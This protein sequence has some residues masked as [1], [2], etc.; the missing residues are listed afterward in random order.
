[1]MS[2]TCRRCRNR[3]EVDAAF[4]G[5][6]L[7][8]PSCNSAVKIQAEEPA[9]A[10]AAPAS[11]PEASP[12]ASPGSAPPAPPAPATPAPAPAPA[13]EAPKSKLRLAGDRIASGEGRACPKCSFIMGTDDV[14][15]A[16]C[17]HNTRTGVS[18]ADVARRR[19]A[20]R[21]FLKLA[22]AVLVLVALGWIVWKAGWLSFDVRDL[23]AEDP[24]PAATGV[25]PETVPGPTGSGLPP[26]PPEIVAEVTRQVTEAFRV[27]HPVVAEGMGAAFERMDGRVLRGVF[28]T[29]TEPGTFILETM[30]G[31]PSTHAFE[32]LKPSFR[33]RCDPAYRADQIALEVKRRLG[34]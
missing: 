14:V 1:M 9:A 17:G 21:Q 16:N 27:D 2:V 7:Y 5:E 13:P 25:V 29:G 19:E 4:L 24:P 12:A 22:T 20:A 8:C 10:P 15:C 18:M 28:R 30:E 34:I 33:L 6:T 32:Q 3:L 31:E 11:M 23:V 26:P